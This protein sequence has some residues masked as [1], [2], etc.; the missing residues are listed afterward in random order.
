MVQGPRSTSFGDRAKGPGL[1]KWTVGSG[2]DGRQ[3]GGDC[4]WADGRAGFFEA[5][6]FSAPRAPT[7]M[8]QRF[9]TPARLTTPMPH[10]DLSATLW[11]G[12]IL[13]AMGAQVNN[14][15]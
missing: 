6:E 8:V 9:D 14:A 4:S 1:P 13:G 11:N 2:G 7:L 15:W 10:P 12:C 5:E 3:F